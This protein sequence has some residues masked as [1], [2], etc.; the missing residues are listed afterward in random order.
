MADFS[1][2]I[3]LS[4]TGKAL[5]KLKGENSALYVFQA[6][7]FGQTPRIAPPDGHLPGPLLRSFGFGGGYSLVWLK[8]TDYLDKTTITWPDNVE[9][10]IATDELVGEG[11]IISIG[12]HIDVAV[13]Q[14]VQVDNNGKMTPKNVG[15]EGVVQILN[16]GTTQRVCGL[17]RAANKK[18]APTCAFPL[19]GMHQIMIGPTNKVLVMFATCVSKVGQTVAIAWN[20]GLLVTADSGSTR[21][22]KYDIENGWSADHNTWADPVN[23]NQE[24]GP[25]L[26]IPSKGH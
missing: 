18:L 24:L 5:D 19:H 25:L 7:Q 14:T 8:L 9:A 12:S 21:A 23:A 4:P 26:I 10:Y 13:G 15:H 3:T 11:S 22:V 1:I 20:Y 6:V 2:E 17:T 16:M